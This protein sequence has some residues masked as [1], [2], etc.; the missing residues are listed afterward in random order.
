MELFWLMAPV[1]QAQSSFTSSLSL[2]LRHCVKSM[3]ASV[4]VVVASGASARFPDHGAL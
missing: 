3:S 1:P 4:K 2:S